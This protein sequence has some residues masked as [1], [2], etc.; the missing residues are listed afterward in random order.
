MQGQPTEWN[1][2]IPS[3]ELFDHRVDVWHFLPVSETRQSFE[4]RSKHLVEFGLSSCLHTRVQ[5][6]CEYERREGG[7][8]LKRLTSTTEVME[9]YRES[10]G[11]DAA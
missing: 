11:V 2:G 5:S 4:A 3:Q 7:R 1:C 6:H 10:Y 8:G 9:L